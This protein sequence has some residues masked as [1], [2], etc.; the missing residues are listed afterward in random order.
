MEKL[1]IYGKL[2]KE[3]I[4]KQYT[5]GLGDGTANTIIDN[6][7]NKISVQVIKTPHKLSIKDVEFDGSQDVI[8]DLSEYAT[9]EQLSQLSDTINTFDKRISDINTIANT[10]LFAYVDT[11]ST[12]SDKIILR[13]KNKN[14][15]ILATSIIKLPDQI[16]A[17]WAQ[18]DSTKPSYIKNKPTKLSQFTND[19][20]GEGS[21]FIT[22][23][24]VDAKVDEK[25]KIIKTDGQGNKYLADDGKYKDIVTNRSLNPV[26]KI[27]GTTQEFINSILADSTAVVGTSY[28]GGV[29]FTDLP[30]PLNNAECLVEILSSTLGSDIKVIHLD[31]Y[32][33]T[34][35]PY[36]WSTIY[37]TQL[38]DPIW[39][40]DVIQSNVDAKLDKTGGTISGDLNITG[41]LEV[42]G[43]T[44]TKDAET[45]LIK[46]NVI[47][48]NSDKQTL[49]TLSGLAINKNSNETYGIMYDPTSDS[50]KLGLGSLDENNKFTFSESGNPVAVRSDSSLLV[51]GHLIKWDSNSY[52]FV[53]S[54]KSV[55]DFVLKGEIKQDYQIVT[56]EPTDKSQGKMIYEKSSGITLGKAVIDKTVSAGQSYSKPAGISD[57]F[58]KGITGGSITAEDINAVENFQYTLFNETNGYVSGNVNLGYLPELTQYIL[59]HDS[60]EIFYRINDGEEQSDL[61]VKKIGTKPYVGNKLTLNR[62]Q[63]LVKEVDENYYLVDLGIGFTPQSFKIEE[64][65]T[66]QITKLKLGDV[67]IN[68]DKGSSEGPFEIANLKIADGTKYNSIKDLVNEGMQEKLTAGS[69]ITIEN[70]VISSSVTPGQTIQYVAIPEAKFENLNK[71]IQYVGETNSNYTNGYF[72]KCIESSEQP[73][74]FNYPLVNESDPE[75]IPQDVSVATPDQAAQYSWISR[76]DPDCVYINLG[77]P[78]E[79]W[80]EDLIFTVDVDGTETTYTLPKDSYWN[81][82]IG[83]DAR[84]HALN[85]QPAFEEQLPGLSNYYTLLMVR[86]PFTSYMTPKNLKT[87]SGQ[88]I[89]ENTGKTTYTWQ[90]VDVQ[91][92]SKDVETDGTTI[93]KTTDGKLQAV[94]LQDETDSKILTAHDIWLACSIKRRKK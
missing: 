16:Q 56:E 81:T 38:P 18:A 25:L 11:D 15:T 20:D 47:V 57:I 90:Q 22:V 66:I 71:V 43:T 44:I 1:Y 94:G 62:T 67:Y 28:L 80:T 83:T 36:H 46:D 14:N 86:F 7:N 52:C 30:T 64:T 60:V 9:N 89:W 26:W 19:G 92:A 51:D 35:S 93:T 39:Q 17:D 40:P 88:I 4:I 59:N 34:T 77:K 45:L 29:E 70:N 42:A 87:A 69:G 61:V 74:T 3:E 32:S 23:A 33:A 8:V 54:G 10:E 91:P 2:N 48:T 53:D 79:Q 73:K 49:L 13:F 63:G 85:T 68:I 72:Y 37:Y 55:D 50:V 6:Q 82:T 12:I 27:D 31:L 65:D 76:T 5:A 41:N 24:D 21:P 58:I 78:S 75:G 84:I